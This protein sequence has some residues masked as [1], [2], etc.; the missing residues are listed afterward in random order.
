MRLKA[1]VGAGTP[2]VFNYD[3]SGNLL[4]ETNSGTETD[5]VYLDGTPIYAITP[6][7][8]ALSA[9]HPD[10][11]G[12]PQK[13]TNSSKAVVW[14]GN[15]DPNGKVTPTTSITMNLRMP[16]QYADATGF[17]HNGFRNYNPTSTTGGG[18]Y[19]ESDPI[20][21]MGGINTYIYGL[22]NPY[23][24]VDIKGLE[25]PSISSGKN[26][27]E[28]TPATV[29]EQ[30]FT[31]CASEA[32]G[33][34]SSAAI[35]S[36]I[37]GTPIFKPVGAGALGSGDITTIGSAASLLAKD[38][39]RSPIAILGTTNICRAAARANEPIAAAL[40]TYGTAA[41]LSCTVTCTVQGGI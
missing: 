41:V 10:H 8:S 32:V 34:A 40:A 36:I 14:T 38:L 19:L 11:L 2:S 29:P 28:A 18:R 4:T 33:E 7:T 31:T 24:N 20:G 3:Q 5:Y 12:T 37:A 21:L 9:I 25:T 17:Y 30:C 35:T 1:T 13:A 15:Y 22:D 39:P 16:G 27:L 23:K 6:S 26:P